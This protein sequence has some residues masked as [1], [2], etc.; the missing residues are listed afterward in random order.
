MPQ[1]LDERGDFP[2]GLLL[3]GGVDPAEELAVFAVQQRGDH[4]VGFDHE[5]L[6]DRMRVGLILGNRVDHR[7]RFVQQQVHVGQIQV[8]HSRLAAAGFDLPGKFFHPPDQLHHAL[9]VV[10][11]FAVADRL[12]LAIRQPPGRLDDRLSHAETGAV[13]FRVVLNERALAQALL[14]FLQAAD[15]VGEHLGKHRQHARGEVH[16]VAPLAGFGVQGTAF[17]DEVRY[18]GDVHAENVPALLA[19]GQADCVVV[20][21][22]RVRVDGHHQLVGEVLP[23]V[24]LGR[25]VRVEA[26]DHFAR[27]GHDFLGEHVGQAIGTDDR[28]GLDIDVLGLAEDFVD[29]A[30]GQVAWMVGELG[31][32]H[33]HLRAR[34]GRAG[35]DLAGF[36][37]RLVGRQVADDNGRGHR[38]AVRQD[39]PRL[40][41]VFERSGEPAVASLEN[42]DDPP[43]VGLFAV[44]HAAPVDRRPHAV[45]GHRPAG[46]V[47]WNEQVAVGIGGIGQH[48]PEP[49]GVSAE[50]ADDF[51]GD[52]GQGQG[53]ARPQH[54]PSLVAQELDRLAK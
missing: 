24:Q 43:A 1:R 12:G 6:D 50:L 27:L 54:H 40:S 39:E 36:V 49:L 20:V 23:V 18:V 30:L 14:R 10:A 38:L 8:Q 13:A 5:H 29:H 31:D 21:P 51:L 22:G 17:L 52:L 2:G 44:S 48:E 11:L 41:G 32:F 34:R 16:A 42:F 3:R 53:V 19:L 25:I 37:A 4:V 47:G 9:G 45:A 35:D 28:K 33:D 15:A 46:G 7:T 26:V